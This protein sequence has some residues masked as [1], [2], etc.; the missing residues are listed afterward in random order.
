VVYLDPKIPPGFNYDGVYD[1]SVPGAIAV[2]KAALTVAKAH[3][4]FL[5]GP[6][7]YFPGLSREKAPGSGPFFTHS[8][9]TSSGNPNC[10]QR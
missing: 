7:F 3:Q 6:R 4:N 5:A 2:T 8:F 10:G 1:T 9:R